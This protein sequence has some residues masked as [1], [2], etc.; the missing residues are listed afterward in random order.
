MLQYDDRKLVGLWFMAFN[1]LS[2]IFHV[3]RGTQFYCWRKSEYLEKTTDLSQVTDTKNQIICLFIY[4]SL[5]Y[6]HTYTWLKIYLNV[7]VFFSL[8]VVLNMSLS[9]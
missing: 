3:Y 5:Y 6:P 1:A 4:A 8:F 7:E 9:V 2:A